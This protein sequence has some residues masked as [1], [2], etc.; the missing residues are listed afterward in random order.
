MLDGQGHLDCQ[1]AKI[2][3][4]VKF[5]PAAFVAPDG[6]FTHVHID[7]L[8][9]LP[10]TEGFRY[11]LTMVDRFSRWPEDV[12]LAETSAETVARA[13]YDNC[14]ARFGAPVFITS[15]QGSQFESQLF[16]ALLFLLVLREF[17]PQRITQLLTAWWNDGIGISRWPS[18]A[19][20][21]IGHACYR[22]YC[23]ACAPA[24][25]SIP[26]PLLRPESGFLS[27]KVL[28]QWSLG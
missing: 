7:I 23:L 9:P 2:S 1:Q 19:T 13:F 3:R 11:C 24:C 12:P 18:C 6:R 17:V 16:S 21:K 28:L 27:R 14:I 22:R 4:H 15:D 20:L 26:T 25:A 10:P 8:R 5:I